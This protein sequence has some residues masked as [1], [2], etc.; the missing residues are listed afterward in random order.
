MGN[1]WSW[2]KNC[3]RNNIM[4]IR[5]IEAK[6]ILVK[7]GL[8]NS[9]WV[10]NPYVGCQFGCKYCY[11]A[12][13]GRWKHPDRDWGD[14]LDVKINAPEILK[15]DL[16][17]LE[18]KY[19]K[20]D[21]GS[22]FFS[23][24]TDPYGPAETKYQLTRRCLEVLADFKYEGEVSILTK[25]PLVTRDIDVLKRLKS[26]VG[27]TITTIEDKVA[28]FL[29]SFAPSP[30]ARIKTLQRLHELGIP[31]Y[32]FVGPL[33]PYFAAR[34]G[35]LEKLFQELKSVGVKRIY[36]EHI[37]LSS[38]IRERL[39]KYLKAYNPRLIFYFK[40]A[41]AKKYR[42]NLEKIIYPIVE[43]EKLEIIGGEI[44]CHE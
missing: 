6:S 2:K 4:E 1:W 38:R 10:I 18:K 21:F 30:T 8:P 3:I 19:G 9:D 37:N 5:E 25:S 12:F 29:E 23:S 27:L 22:I 11:A 41:E 36:I 24:V 33:L 39:Y 42:E 26:E 16:E 44:L 13:M 35:K 32:A 17:R 14:F 28:K 31:I 7:S 15:R 40:K 20:K 34:K 43:R